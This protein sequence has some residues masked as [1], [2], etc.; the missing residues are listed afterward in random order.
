[1][2]RRHVTLVLVLSSSGFSIAVVYAFFGAPDV[3][4]VAVLIETIVALLVFGTLQ[5]IP[6]ETLQEGAEVP[7]G[8]ARR[9]ALVATVAGGFVMAIVWGTLS[10]PSSEESAATRLV[11]LAPEAHA[12]DV[13]TV[14]LT[15]FRALDTL[16]EITVVALVLLGVATL[17]YGG[18]LP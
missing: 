17:L 5:L 7:A 11:R 14:I 8:Q 15:D 13:V 1:M 4:L 2:A 10:Q 6:R 3:A 9:K 18:R 16:G 12:K